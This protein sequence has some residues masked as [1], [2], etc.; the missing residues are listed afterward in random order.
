[1]Q[2][3]DKIDTELILHIGIDG[4]WSST[5]FATYFEA[6]N[7]LY[8][9]VGPWHHLPRGWD[10]SDGESLLLKSLR[11]APT[12]LIVRKI[13]FESPGFTDFVGAGQVIG[14][15]KD[16]LVELLHLGINKKMKMAEAERLSAEGVKMRAEA[17]RILFESLRSKD[18]ATKLRAEAE[19]TSAEAQKIRAEAELLTLQ[20]E[21]LSYELI[22][23]R[24]DELK[25]RNYEQSEIDAIEAAVSLQ[26]KRLATAMDRK[27]V[28]SI[29]ANNKS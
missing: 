7:D 27:K 10:L 4:T 22:R 2:I 18:E 21:N 13:R 14:H 15:L 20:R 24:L 3:K 6:I 17:N 8:L 1:M 26:T 29:N 16:F 9:F 28:V 19:K 5:E 25:A 23:G 11:L 12:I